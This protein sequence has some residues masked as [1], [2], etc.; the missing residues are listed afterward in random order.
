MV[1]LTPSC[2]L[3]GLA[4]RL[5]LLLPMQL[6]QDWLD[7]RQVRQVCIEPAAAQSKATAAATLLLL[8]S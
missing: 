3:T 5:L 4:C 8:L 1:G 7:P 6:L 2:S